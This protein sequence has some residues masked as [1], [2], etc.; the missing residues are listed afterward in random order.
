M[1]EVVGDALLREPNPNLGRC[2]APLW[3]RQMLTP[4]GEVVI[5]RIVEDIQGL[6]E[7]GDSENQKQMAKTVAKVI[8]SDSDG[9]QRVDKALDEI[10]AQEYEIVEHNLGK[11][12]DDMECEEI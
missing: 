4:R 3:L 10:A 8:R 11:N 1:P 9:H 12:T 6:M 5:A 7:K 2:T